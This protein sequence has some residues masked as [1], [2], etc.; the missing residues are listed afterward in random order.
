M[1]TLGIAKKSY[2]A[3]KLL[4]NFCWRRDRKFRLS[5]FSEPNIFLTLGKTSSILLLLIIWH[6]L[7]LFLS[8][9]FFLIKCN[10]TT[11]QRQTRQ[12]IPCLFHVTASFQG[13]N[14]VGDGD[15]VVVS[16]LSKTEYDRVFSFVFSVICLGE[17]FAA[18][19]QKETR[20]REKFIVAGKNS[21]N[22]R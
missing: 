17:E 1:G 10:A 3:D 2:F 7:T 14:F 18:P 4:N 13:G 12:S 11:T 22:S 5:F 8:I 21:V 15:V 6:L 20:F 9:P 19:Q 16:P